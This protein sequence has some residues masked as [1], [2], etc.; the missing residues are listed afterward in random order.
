MDEKYLELRNRLEASRKQFS[1]QM[2]KI[3]KESSELRV[4]YSMATHGKLLDTLP[5][6]NQSHF[7]NSNTFSFTGDS[8]NCNG[9]GFRVSGDHHFD[10]RL[11]CNTAG[12]K[13]GGK[14]RATSAHASSGKYATSPAMS[15][16]F[17]PGPSPLDTPYTN[18]Q[19]FNFQGPSADGWNPKSDLPYDLAPFKDKAA[20]LFAQGMTHNHN[21][22]RV[23]ADQKEKQILRKI[24]DKQK[25]NGLNGWTDERLQELVKG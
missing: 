25:K 4:K 22:N 24:T 9:E 19:G 6:P 8:G 12:G 15:S 13:R 11:S 5:L 21:Y 20:K 10:P 16:H 2:S 7:N 14:P 23:D 18:G 17:R 1:T 3:Q